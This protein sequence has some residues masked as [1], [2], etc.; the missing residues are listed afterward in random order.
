MLGFLT[1]A[2]AQLKEANQTGTY[3]FTIKKKGFEP[4]YLFGTIHLP[5]RRVTELPTGVVDAYQTSEAVYTEIPMEPADMLV[6]SQAMLLPKGQTLR[7]IVPAETI[8]RFSEELSAINP[9]LQ[10]GPFLSMKVW[11]A[12]SM[13]L[14]LQTQLDN[15]GVSAM[16]LALYS[17]AKEAGKRVGGLETAKEQLDIFDSFSVQEQVLLLDSMLDTMEEMR[18]ENRNYTD[19]I[20]AAYLS[21]DL[22]TLEELMASYETADQALQSKFEKLFITDRNKLMVQRIE[23]R[24]N[25]HPDETAFFAIGAAHL[26]GE[27][28]V[29]SLLRKAGFTVNQV[30]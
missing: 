17:I 29:P 28:G 18:R 30:Q 15:P 21:G 12:G 1:P 2:W 8:E 27:G 13:L 9:E 10:V 16:D 3:L 25:A 7:D 11:A 22:K 23:M 14:M 6:A 5:D 26:Y 19:E 4:S 24:L 20:V